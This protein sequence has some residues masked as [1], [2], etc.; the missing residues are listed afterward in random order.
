[1]TSTRHA[2][3][4]FATALVATL[5]LSACNRGGDDA[6]STPAATPAPTAQSPVTTASPSDAMRPVNPTEGTDAAAVTGVELGTA[7]DADNR[8]TQAG[9]TF[10]P[11]D[12]IHASVLTDAAGTDPQATALTARW[13]FQDGQVVK[14]DTADAQLTGAGMTSFSINSP[15]GFP[16]GRYKVEILVNGEAVQS[17]GFEVR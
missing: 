17:R 4:A 2:N 14:E 11:T 5:A 13:S 10:A 9:A 6:A 3:A 8:V 1:M 7:V 16:T 15:G 12:T